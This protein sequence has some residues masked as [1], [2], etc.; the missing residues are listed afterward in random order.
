M[1][2]KY[3]LKYRA[4]IDGL[5]A[6]AVGVVVIFHLHMGVLTG[7]FVGVDVFFVISGYLITRLILKELGE[8]RFSIKNFYV[9]RFRRLFPAL[10]FTLL[11]STILAACLLTY[12]DFRTYGES[13]LA[14]VLSISNFYFWQSSGYFATTAFQRPLLHTWSLSVEEQFYVFWP[15]LLIALYKFRLMKFTPHLLILIIGLSLIAAELMINKKS[16]TAFYLLPFRASELALGGLIA[17]MPD[18]NNKSEKLGSLMSLMGL[19]LIFVPVFL[20]TEASRF[21]GILAL[22]PCIGTGLIIYAGPDNIVSKFLS[23]KAFVFTG[24]ISY[25]FYLIHWPLFVFWKFYTF[26]PFNLTDAIFF[27]VASYVLAVFMYKYVQTPLRRG[28]FFKFKAKTITAA[29]VSIMLA[30]GA[31]GYVIVKSNGFPTRVPQSLDALDIRTG[32]VKQTDLT[33]RLKE[34]FTYG[35]FSVRGSKNQQVRKIMITGDSHA[36]RL[37]PFGFYLHQQETSQII[38]AWRTGC[39]PMLAMKGVSAAGQ[40]KGVNC[41][42]I[43]RKF[44]Q[45]IKDEGVDV[46]VIAGRWLPYLGAEYEGQDP[47]KRRYFVK[48][49]KRLTDGEYIQEY[50]EALLN[51]TVQALVELDVKVILMSQVPPPAENLRGCTDVPTL[52]ISKEKQLARCRGRDRGETLEVLKGLDEIFERVASRHNQL[53]IFP[54]KYFCPEAEK[55]CI[56]SWKKRALYSD[57]NHLNKYGAWYLAQESEKEIS[58]FIQSK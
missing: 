21:P 58:A 18:R 9:R 56:A 44:L 35:R 53:A 24:L 50:F 7:G 39:F 25:S 54:S 12:Q 14:S 20:Y 8:G 17:A 49:D 55:T 34:Q 51:E 19:I 5:R 52:L 48:D 33:K 36:G 1:T 47:K 2:S 3:N 13:M 15:V 30:F 22:I 45:T 43:R 16:E 32:A 37:A 10:I 11:F 42:R 41:T 23:H 57:D 26:R 29:L 46:V 6:I 4:D 40:N 28:Q 27:L 38:M 31:F